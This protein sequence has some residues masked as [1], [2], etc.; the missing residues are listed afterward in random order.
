M[1]NNNSINSNY[2][3]EGKNAL[4]KVYKEFIFFMFMYV[5]LIVGI[6]IAV[7][8]IVFVL[9]LGNALLDPNLATVLYSIFGIIG[10]TS[11]TIP[12]LSFI[13][14]VFIKLM[15]RTMTIKSF[16]SP[17]I[18]SYTVVYDGAGNLV[19]SDEGAVVAANILIL[20]FRI[21]LRLVVAICI[22]WLYPL[23]GLPVVSRKIKKHYDM[24]GFP[25]I[26]GS[27]G[28]VGLAV[29]SYFVIAAAAVGMAIYGYQTGTLNPE[30]IQNNPEEPEGAQVVQVQLDEFEYLHY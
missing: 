14:I 22:G 1:S 26:L 24:K 4:K 5:W 21:V 29:L 11:W 8:G 17:A 3:Q 20:M 6:A 7:I 27:L 2:S 9:F 15:R 25:L 28:I 19:S 16:F 10:M 23:I 30:Y 13:I 12:M 18:D